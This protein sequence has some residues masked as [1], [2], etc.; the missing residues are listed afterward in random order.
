MRRDA[1]STLQKKVQRRH[2]FLHTKG[3]G[4][5]KFFYQ[6]LETSPVPQIVKIALFGS[7]VVSITTRI[8]E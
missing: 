8:A 6:A 1:K 3:F 7:E 4:S 2:G 5:V